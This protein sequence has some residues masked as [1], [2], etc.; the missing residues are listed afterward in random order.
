MKFC[1]CDTL[2]HTHTRTHATTHTVRPLPFC[3]SHLTEPIFQV[4]FFDV[5]HFPCFE[6]LLHRRVPPLSTEKLFNFSVSRFSCTQMERTKTAHRKNVKKLQ[7]IEIYNAFRVACSSHH[8]ALHDS[9]AFV[10]VSPLP[11]L[12]YMSSIHVYAVRCNNSG[13]CSIFVAH[14]LSFLRTILPNMEVTVHAN[15]ANTNYI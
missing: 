3:R 10:L 6:N 12:L 13:L 4:F 11:L 5:F 14:I 1:C 7:L 8:V 9:R 2:T 15:R